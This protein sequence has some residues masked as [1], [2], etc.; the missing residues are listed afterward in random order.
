MLFVLLLFDSDETGTKQQQQQ[1]VNNLW[2]SHH[3]V[4]SSYHLLHH[5][6]PH[7]LIDMPLPSELRLSSKWDVC[8]E[9]LVFNVSAGALMAG[10]VSIVI[11]SECLQ[12]LFSCLECCFYC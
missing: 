3:Q 5:C 2:T 7:S 1:V 6:Q 11:F 10:L 9:R 8:L 12:P 4:C